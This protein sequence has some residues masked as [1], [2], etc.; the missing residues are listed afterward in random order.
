VNIGRRLES[1]YSYI[2]LTRDKMLINK[3][4]LKYGCLNFRFEILEYC[5][6]Y[7][8]IKREQHYLDLF[9]PEYNV[10]PKAGSSLGQC[11]SIK[12]PT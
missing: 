2:A 9:K 11:A 1:Y 4:M 12:N 3:A 8:A 6:P 10:L 5:E 7:E